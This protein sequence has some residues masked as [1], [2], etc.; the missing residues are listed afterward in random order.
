LHWYGN[1]WATRRLDI[2]NIDTYIE[3]DLSVSGD[4]F[5]YNINKTGGQTIEIGGSTTA[6]IDHYGE[7]ETDKIRVYGSMTANSIGS[8]SA[9]AFTGLPT[10]DPETEGAVWRDGTYLRISTG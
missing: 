3:E 8:T 10:S 4:V 7:I 5:L 2:T 6:N 9:V 1:D